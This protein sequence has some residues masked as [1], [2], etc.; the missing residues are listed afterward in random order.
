MLSS[1]DLSVI[2]VGLKSAAMGYSMSERILFELTSGTLITHLSNLY[3]SVLHIMLKYVFHVCHIN[4]P[5]HRILELSE[6]TGLHVDQLLFCT[7]HA[8]EP[9]KF[10]CKQCQISLC[11]TC[12][13]VTH[14]NHDTVTVQDALDE[15][16]PSIKSDLKLIDQ[17]CDMMG[18][19]RA[20]ICNKAELLR[21]EYSR[22][23]NLVEKSAEQAIE[24][25]QKDKENLIA[26]LIKE[27]EKQVGNV[28]NFN[29]LKSNLDIR[30]NVSSTMEKNLFQVCK[31][32]V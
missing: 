14:K 8:D 20:I 2:M 16:L 24:S 30:V 32:S 3:F 22:C 26:T 15:L 13:V 17:T 7:T 4:I 23:K 10:F 21:T 18:R 12:H 29:F 25:I 28:F 11:I 1:I 9:I 5:G 6:D 19:N 27:E 31:I